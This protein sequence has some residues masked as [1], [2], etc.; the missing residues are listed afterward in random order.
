MFSFAGILFYEFYNFGGVFQKIIPFVFIIAFIPIYLF[1]RR[2][3]ED[4]TPRLWR[5]NLLIIESMS[6]LLIYAGGNYLVVRELSISMMG[7]QIEEGND[8]PFAF[9]FYATTVII[10]ITYLYYGIRNRDTVL[11]RVSLIVLAFS[12][13]TFKYY[14]SLGRPEIT[15]TI[16]GA[17]LLVISI[18][19]IN[20]L[21]TMRRGF[22]RDNLLSEK[23]GNMNVESFLISQTMGGNQAAV[24]NQ[25]KGGGGEFGGGGASGNF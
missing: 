2:L 13:V 24:D 4:N 11:L 23:W 20:Y 7:L 14:F 12:V 22:T 17:I 16:A 1:A 5:N 25:F 15:L 3:K 6:L 10:P 21:K 9:I 18:A 8:I 19:L